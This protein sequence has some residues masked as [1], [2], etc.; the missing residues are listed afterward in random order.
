[1]LKPIVDIA[2]MIIV[3]AV[4]ATLVSHGKGTANVVGSI[5]GG[6]AKVI[7]AAQGG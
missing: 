5:T 4:I 1:M 3:L 7:N 6:F 2:T